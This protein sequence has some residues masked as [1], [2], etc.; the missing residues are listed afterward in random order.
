MNRFL[1]FSSLLLSLA[2]NVYAQSGD[3]FVYAGSYTNPTPTTT[4]ARRGS[5]S[6]TVGVGLPL[7]S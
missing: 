2:S 7:V 3:Y 4:S 5:G 1:V 6:V